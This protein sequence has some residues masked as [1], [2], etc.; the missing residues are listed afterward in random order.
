MLFPI[1]LIFHVLLGLGFG[2]SG[3]ALKRLWAGV[4]LWSALV[5]IVA[6][7]KVQLPQATAG[8]VW[9]GTIFFS[10]CFG[11]TGLGLLAG[12]FLRNRKG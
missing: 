12:S 9:I 10:L 11:S 7:W 4:L 8:P 6:A 2:F 1:F 3:Y 5:A